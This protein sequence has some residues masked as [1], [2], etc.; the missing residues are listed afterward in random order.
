MNLSEVLVNLGLKVGPQQLG[1][2]TLNALRAGK[3]GEGIVSQAHGELYEAA[4]RKNLFF[5]YCAGQAMTASH[6]TC[7][8]NIV[9][10]PLG[11]GI[12]LALSKWSIMNYAT[13]ATTTGFTLS[14]SVQLVVPSTVTT[15]STAT[16]CTYLGP[17]GTTTAKAKAYNAVTLVTTPT[18]IVLLAHNTADIAATGVDQ[19]DGDFEGGIVVPPGY[20]VAIQAYGAASAS[21]SVTSTLWWEEVPIVT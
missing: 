20:V 8:G 10:N 6:A 18:P 1:E 14:Y 5:N 4:S 2:G 9:W 3:T 16:G 7:V 19:L 12:L 21:T 17:I 13:S 15:V 11:S